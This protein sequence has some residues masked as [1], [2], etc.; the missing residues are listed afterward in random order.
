[1]EET[2]NQLATET[3]D[4]DSLAEE[5]LRKLNNDTFWKHS[6]GCLS[7]NIVDEHVVRALDLDEQKIRTLYNAEKK[8][9]GENVNG[10][11]IL[12]GMLAE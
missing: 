5:T 10:A 8:K 9:H 3:I 1:M 11:E 7:S 4:W 12:Y 2:M 6:N